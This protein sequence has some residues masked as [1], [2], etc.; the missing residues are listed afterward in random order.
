MNAIANLSGGGVTRFE[1]HIQP[2]FG[3]TNV[4]L[5][6]HS[7]PSQMHIQNQLSDNQATIGRDSAVLFSRSLIDCF[8]IDCLQQAVQPITLSGN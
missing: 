6:N 4:S 8:E 2:T 1:P 7:V 5:S 3:W